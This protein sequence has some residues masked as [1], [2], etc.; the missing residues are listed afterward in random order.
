MK[1]LKSACYLYSVVCCCGVYKC[2]RD[3]LQRGLM[4]SYKR[5][6]DLYT[7]SFCVYWKAQIWRRS[8]FRRMCFQN[9]SKSV[10]TLS[11]PYNIHV[12]VTYAAVAKFSSI[13]RLNKSQS[14]I[15]FW[16]VT[17]LSQ[18][19]ESVGVRHDWRHDPH[20]FNKFI[21]CRWIHYLWRKY[22]CTYQ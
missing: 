3:C 12:L 16:Q 13:F 4:E 22:T 8:E 17:G 6:Y 9:K 1:F 7:E 19:N 15:F 18:V 11:D 2:N 21:K 10:P 20:L 14:H 5:A